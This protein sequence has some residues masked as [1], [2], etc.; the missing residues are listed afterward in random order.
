[1]RYSENIKKPI[2]NIQLAKIS[3]AKGLEIGETMSVTVTGKVFSVDSPREE[4]MYGP[5]G[6]KAKMMPGCICIEIED[7]TVDGGA[8]SMDDED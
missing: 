3:Q 2:A 1:M 8:G 7:I 6:G 5:G 4:T